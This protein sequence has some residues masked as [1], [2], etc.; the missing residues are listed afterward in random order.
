MKKLIVFNLTPTMMALTWVTN[1]HGLSP[2]PKSCR[3]PMFS[4]MTTT[5]SNQ[6]KG[7]VKK[8]T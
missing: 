5:G 1:A 7:K 6:A 4:L 2:Q 3:S 8:L